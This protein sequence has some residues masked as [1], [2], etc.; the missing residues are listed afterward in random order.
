MS[1]A[2]NSDKEI[3]HNFCSCGE[4]LYSEKEERIRV[5]KGRKVTIYLKRREIEI[6]CPNCDEITKVKFSCM[7]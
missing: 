7:D 6:I 1:K 2:K 5:A 4:Y 3:G